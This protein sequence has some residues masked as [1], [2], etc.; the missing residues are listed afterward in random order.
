MKFILFAIFF[1]FA[2]SHVQSQSFAQGFDETSV[3]AIRGKVPES[4]LVLSSRPLF[5]DVHLVSTKNEKALRKVLEENSEISKVYREYPSH[6]KEDLAEEIENEK[7]DFDWT[8]ENLFNDPQ[9]S[10]QWTHRSTH[11]IATERAY[12]E[13]GK[14]SGEPVIV[15]V[16]D[17]GV[18]YQHP[19]LKNVMW[20]NSGEIA[21]NG[22]DDDGNGYI[23][24]VYGID[25]LSRK[26]GQATGDPNDTHNHGTH[27]S[28]IIGAEQDNGVGIAG[29][30]SNVQ[31]MAIRTVPNKGDEKDVDVAESF[32]Y[33]AKNGAK[34]INCSFGKKRNEG[35]DLVKDTLE[36]IRKEYGVLVIAAAGNA[37]KNTD[38]TR[39]Y[40]SSLESVNLI[41]VAATT[42]SGRRADFSNYG[43]LSV[44]LGAPGDRILSTVRQGR[45][46]SY[47]G[48]SMASPTVA[49]VAAE[50]L[51]HYP[52]LDPVE[53]KA[54][55]LDSVV[56]TRAMHNR[57]V[58]GGSVN[59]Y[60]ALK[61][62]SERVD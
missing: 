32:I 34:I 16:V 62:A 18:D 28:G 61:L 44:D 40:P 42:S 23:D 8:L 27:V 14:A 12:A 19:D 46:R 58:S 52:E 60:Q 13:F 37:K 4:P 54:V 29:V 26:N 56:P 6:S 24:D 1:I 7:L 53:L 38:R 3:I 11:G 21:G 22:I 50:V 47:R 33:A 51:A 45:Y 5:G 41:S 48:T 59:L 2:L 43:K 9:Y 55:L 10:K 25:T 30:A 17:T 20:K 15:A 31:I 36:H 35:G 49:G 57:T 39:H